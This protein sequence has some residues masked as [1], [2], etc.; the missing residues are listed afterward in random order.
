MM[1][2]VRPE[3]SAIERFL[4]VDLG[5]VGFNLVL[6]PCPAVLLPVLLISGDVLLL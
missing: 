1:A 3:S 2:I 4:N 6:I 5:E